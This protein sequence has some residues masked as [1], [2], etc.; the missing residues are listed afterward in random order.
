MEICGMGDFR[1]I[2]TWFV[3]PKFLLTRNHVLNIL[4]GRIIRALHV[5][6]CT[7]EKDHEGEAS[8]EAESSCDPVRED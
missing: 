6:D 7:E 2:C 4:G 8:G 1:T 5:H 3:H